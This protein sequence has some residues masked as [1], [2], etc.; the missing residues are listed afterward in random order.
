MARAMA[1]VLVLAMDADAAKAREMEE[2]VGVALAPVVGEP[3][4]AT[5]ATPGGPPQ[6]ARS[7]HPLRKLTGRSRLFACVGV[8]AQAVKTRRA[9][10]NTFV[11]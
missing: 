2:V 5:K 4:W 7:G 9:A 3:V 11:P 8:S 10:L 6:T 1:L